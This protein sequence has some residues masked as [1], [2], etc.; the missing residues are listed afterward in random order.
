M[1]RVG[2]IGV[3]KVDSLREVEGPLQTV[4]GDGLKTVSPYSFE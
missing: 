1:P 3:I 2:D 4:L